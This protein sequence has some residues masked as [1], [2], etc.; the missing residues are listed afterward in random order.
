M[1]RKRKV[2]K[3]VSPRRALERLAQQRYGRDAPTF[4]WSVTQELRNAGLVSVPANGRGGVS[5]TRAG[6]DFLRARAEI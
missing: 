4:N 3:P 6:Q 5:I 1:K 2:S